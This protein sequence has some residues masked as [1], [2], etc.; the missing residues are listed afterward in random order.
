MLDTY[1]VGEAQR[2]YVEVHAGITIHPDLYDYFI[3]CQAPLPIPVRPAHVAGHIVNRGTLFGVALAER[4]RTGDLTIRQPLPARIWSH[5][6]LGS[7]VAEC[8]AGGRTAAP[9]SSGLVKSPEPR[10]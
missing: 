4:N 5:S 3:A 7:L 10:A 9:S 6:A 8:S 2:T 1:P